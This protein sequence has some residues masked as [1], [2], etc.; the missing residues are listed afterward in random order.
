MSIILFSKNQSFCFFCFFSQSYI[1]YIFIFRIEKKK[2]KRYFVRPRFINAKS[3]TSKV[4]ESRS[5]CAGSTGRRRTCHHQSQ[6]VYRRAW[7]TC[8]VGMIVIVFCCGSGAVSV[9]R[10][11]IHQTANPVTLVVYTW[12]CSNEF[13][14]IR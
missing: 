12:H 6:Q 5:C 7:Q 10:V 4:G 3:F 2:K 13:E 1:L 14:E 11:S 8:I 9:A